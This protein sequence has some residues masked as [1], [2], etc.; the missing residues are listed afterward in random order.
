MKAV[1]SLI[2]L[3]LTA[4]PAGADTLRVAVASN[5]S[6]AAQDIAAGFEASTGHEV[7]LAFGSIPQVVCGVVGA[8]LGLLGLFCLRP[9]RVCFDRMSGTVKLS[10]AG[11]DWLEGHKRIPI[12]EVAAVQVCSQPEGSFTT[13]EMN[14]VLDR[15]G[16]EPRI[17]QRPP[18]ERLNLMAHGDE[19]AVKADARKLAE[20]LGRPLLD[21]SQPSR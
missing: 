15:P 21:H 17:L 18:G 13:F 11:P 10:K 3:L 5:F 19:A 2:L 4:L 8:L 14:L 6:T 9:R 16:G 12:Q 20:F 1:A 7:L